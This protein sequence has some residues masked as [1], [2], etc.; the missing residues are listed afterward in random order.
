MIIIRNNR[1]DSIRDQRILER[2]IRIQAMIGLIVLPEYC[3]LLHADPG[4]NRVVMIHPV[5]N[6][7]PQPEQFSGL[8]HP[9]ERV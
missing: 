3:E 1:L 5:I 7:D 8:L 2:T 9:N 4:E 6:E